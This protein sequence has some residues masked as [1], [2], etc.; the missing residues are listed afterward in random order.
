MFPALKD[1][2]AAGFKGQVKKELLKGAG[3]VVLKSF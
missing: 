2:T 1:N 3:L